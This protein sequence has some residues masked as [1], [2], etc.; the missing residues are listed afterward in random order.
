M[1]AGGRTV[2][3]GGGIEPDVEVY[4]DPRLRTQEYARALAE[5]KAYAFEEVE[6]PRDFDAEAAGRELRG[7]LADRG[8]GL[9]DAEWRLYREPLLAEFELALLARTRGERAAARA[10]ALGD[11]FVRAA[12]T[13]L[14]QPGPFARGQ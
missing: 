4:E 11:P 10:R 1:T 12:V 6:S 13:A 9:G 7:Y 3:G 14:R 5:V 2:Y 8:Q